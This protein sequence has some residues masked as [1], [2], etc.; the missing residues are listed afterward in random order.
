MVVDYLEGI[1][2]AAI[3]L[4]EGNKTLIFFFT[5]IKRHNFYSL[6]LIP[7]LTLDTSQGKLC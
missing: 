1:I 4:K 5:R 3:N 2:F 7:F 6:E